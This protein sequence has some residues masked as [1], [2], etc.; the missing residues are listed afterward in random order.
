MG[1]SADLLPAVGFKLTLHLP[2][3]HCLSVITRVTITT[4]TIIITRVNIIIIAM[5]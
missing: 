3:C 1:A 4:I 2:H 5:Y